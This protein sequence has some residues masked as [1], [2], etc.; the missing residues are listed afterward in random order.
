MFKEVLL[1]FQLGQYYSQKVNDYPEPKEILVWPF[2]PSR[3]SL[4]NPI[5]WNQ[6]PI[7]DDYRDSGE[8][9]FNNNS[10]T[11]FIRKNRNKQTEV[12]KLTIGEGIRL[13]EQKHTKDEIHFTVTIGGTDSNCKESWRPI[14]AFLDGV[15][16]MLKLVQ[17]FYNGKSN[18]SDYIMLKRDFMF[19]EYTLQIFTR[20]SKQC[21]FH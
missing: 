6:P 21:L 9:V 1:W 15:V 13:I 7:Y 17:P 5:D 8:V 11:N 4:E 19:S 12:E 16:F 20:N 14:N 10:D 18:T 3:S 2:S